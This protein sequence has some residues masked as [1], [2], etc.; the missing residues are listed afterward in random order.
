MSF[1]GNT[2]TGVQGEDL[3]TDWDLEVARRWLEGS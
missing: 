2:V 3:Y 1:L